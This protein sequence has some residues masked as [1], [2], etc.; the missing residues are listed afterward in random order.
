MSMRHTVAAVGIATAI[1]GLGG[2]AVYA[3]TDAVGS[4]HHG[5]PPGM[6]GP[7][8]GMPGPGAHGLG[9]DGC[10]RIRG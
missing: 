7:P 3:A 10:A 1:A 6:G 5:G 9:T 4:G 2:A 8:P